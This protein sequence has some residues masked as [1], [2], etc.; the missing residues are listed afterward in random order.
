MILTFS[1]QT[2]YIYTYTRIE[3]TQLHTT[4]FCYTITASRLI[5]PSSPHRSGGAKAEQIGFISGWAIHSRNDTAPELES[6]KSIP[7]PGVKDRHAPQKDKDSSGHHT[8]REG[9]IVTWWLATGAWL[10]S[11]GD[12][13]PLQW[14]SHVR[15]HGSDPWHTIAEDVQEN[16]N[17]THL[18]MAMIDVDIN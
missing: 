10:C 3:S 8:G 1:K 6:L 4:Y 17:L 12:E 7:P 15:H 18:H 16:M 11:V 14:P 13:Q 9:I 5:N 2:K